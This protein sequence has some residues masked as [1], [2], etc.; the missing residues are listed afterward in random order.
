MLS[1]VNALSAA[2]G[3]IERAAPATADHNYCSTAAI[4]VNV[5]DGEVN[6]NSVK[7]E[8][9][10]IDKLGVTVGFELNEI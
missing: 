4:T 9:H 1:W 6:D 2:A 10:I 8:Q 3:A 5:E 7:D